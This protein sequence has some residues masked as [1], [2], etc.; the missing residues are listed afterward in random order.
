MKK[1][2]SKLIKFIFYI[3]LR[4]LGIILAS[5]IKYY[6]LISTYFIILIKIVFNSNDLNH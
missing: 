5:E 1:Y 3:L 2:F 4:I 6:D